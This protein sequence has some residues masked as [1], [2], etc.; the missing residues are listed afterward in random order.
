MQEAA[1]VR[2]ALGCDSYIVP[3]VNGQRDFLVGG[4]VISLSADS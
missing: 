4:Q 3:I 1:E 2:T